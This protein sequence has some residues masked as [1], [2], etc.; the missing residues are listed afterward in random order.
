MTTLTTERL[1]LRPA[2]WDDLDALHAIFTQP[3]AMRFWSRPPHTDLDQTREWLGS[4]I[5]SPADQSE[6]FIV[7]L[8]G[9]TIGKAGFHRLPEIGFILDP[10]CWGRGLAREALSA[11]L[12]HLF[13]T[14]ATPFAEADV[15]P[16]N[17][18]SLRLLGKLGFEEHGR[19][20][21]TY[22]IA[23]E[24]VDSVYLSLTR[25]RWREIVDRGEAPPSCSAR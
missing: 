25:A 15:D 9:R 11:V 2:R 22:C 12:D 10:S 13:A 14:H 16:R 23:G 1:I 6:D 21:H 3:V 4:M 5:D 18:A 7:E 20:T 24:W 19:A 8:E 17:A